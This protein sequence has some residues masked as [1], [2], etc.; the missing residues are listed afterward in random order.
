MTRAKPPH[1][2]APHDESLHDETSR[3]VSPDSDAPVQD[4][5][6]P[7]GRSAR[8]LSAWAANLLATA[9]IIAAGLTFGRQA[10]LWWHEK[11]AA[12]DVSDVAG[13][14]L[15]DES[16]PHLLEFGDFPFAL[17]REVFEGD[18]RAAVNRLLE[19]CRAVARTGVP[20][21]AAAGPAEAVLLKRVEHCP[22]LAVENNWKL[23]ALD[24]PLPLAT[25]VVEQ[26]APN[27]TAPRQRVVCWGLA[28]PELGG[29]PTDED[30]W[31]LFTWS[32]AGA[33][34]AASI[35]APPLPRGAK[36]LMRLAAEDGSA[37]TAFRGGGAPRDAM[38]FYDEYFSQASHQSASASPWREVGGVWHARFQQTAGTVDVQLMIGDDGV[39]DG[40]LTLLNAEQTATAGNN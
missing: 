12:P 35:D 21:E 19:R 34:R 18:R 38:D 30:R 5:P 13:P 39:L 14:L 3:S 15:G 37:L 23:F 2:E 1:T 16:S 33:V 40:V 28:L 27:D 31:T 24:D 32:A 10:L 29:K 7:L 6:T 26:P 4:A 9:L 8:R 22:P 20:P 25:A 17:K 11:P 36:R